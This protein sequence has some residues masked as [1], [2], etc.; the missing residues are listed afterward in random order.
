[1]EYIV[2]LWHPP[3]V[4]QRMKA[5][6]PR[7][8][9][10]RRFACTCRT[11]PWTSTA[12]RK[13]HKESTVSAA[14]KSSTNYWRLTKKTDENECF[15]AEIAPYRGQFLHPVVG[16]S[17]WGQPDFL[18]ELRKRGIGQERYMAQELKKRTRPFKESS[19]WRFKVFRETITSWQMSGSG[20]YI[21][22]LPWRMY[23]VEW[24]TRNAVKN[25]HKKSFLL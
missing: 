17:Q 7:K 6:Q 19:F 18:W 15:K 11:P 20:V 9:C 23:C 16:R 13:V 1:M 10:R 21:G 14:K 12:G 5:V 2:K 3:R 4:P 8:P 25:R 22:Q 24:N